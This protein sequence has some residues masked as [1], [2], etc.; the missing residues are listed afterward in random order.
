LLVAAAVFGPAVDP[1]VN[2]KFG[3]FAEP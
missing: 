3:R 2:R 1:V